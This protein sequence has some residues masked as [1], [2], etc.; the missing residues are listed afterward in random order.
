MIK[1]FPYNDNLVKRALNLFNN[2]SFWLVAPHKLF[3]PGIYRSIEMI[4]GQEALHVKYSVG[5][6]HQEILTHGSLDKNYLP[7]S[8]QNVCS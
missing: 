5:G 3:E 2:D 1:K 6:L 4:D 8:Y 7:T